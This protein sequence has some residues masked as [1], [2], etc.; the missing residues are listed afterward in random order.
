MKDWQKYGLI[1]V[2]GYYLSAEVRTWTR[3]NVRPLADL[4]DRILFPTATAPTTQS[5]VP[6]TPGFEPATPGAFPGTL[7]T[8]G[9]NDVL[10]E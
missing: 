1:Y 4:L 9:I 6:T 8:P 7:T 3:A 2:L 10:G 5:L